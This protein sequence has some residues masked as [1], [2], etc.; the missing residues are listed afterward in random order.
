MNLIILTENIAIELLLYSVSHTRVNTN[1]IVWYI[2]STRGAETMTQYTLNVYT[3]RI[4]INSELYTSTFQS[5][6]MAYNTVTYTYTWN[7]IRRER[8][9]KRRHPL[10]NGVRLNNKI[11]VR[12]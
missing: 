8:M 4:Q 6:F 9:R 1:S 11:D 3:Q 12:W 5:D 10:F 7:V 2:L